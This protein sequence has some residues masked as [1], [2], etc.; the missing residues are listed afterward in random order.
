MK[1]SLLG[2]WERD[3]P[4]LKEELMMIAHNFDPCYGN[5]MLTR[6]QTHF[7]SKNVWYIYKRYINFTGKDEFNSWRVEVHPTDENKEKPSD[8]LHHEFEVMM[9]EEFLDGDLFF[10]ENIRPY[11]EGSKKMKL[12][13]KYFK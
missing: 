7:S 5:R 6:N 10:A 4:F 13:R 12:R 3:N 9:P 8:Q 1:H 2:R 11:E